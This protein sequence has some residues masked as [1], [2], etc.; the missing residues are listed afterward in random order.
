VIESAEMRRRVASGEAL[1]VKLRRYNIFHD[2]WCSVVPDLNP[3][4]WEAIA[5]TGRRIEIARIGPPHPFGQSPQGKA[6]RVQHFPRRM[7]LGRAGSKPRD[8]GSDRG[9]RLAD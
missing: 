7:V 1:R 3:A 6:A 5:G 2:G 9:Y 8:L 4:I